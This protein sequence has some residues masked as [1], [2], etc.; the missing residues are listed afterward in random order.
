VDRALRNLKELQRENE[1][2]RQ[3]MQRIKANPKA[4]IKPIRDE[5]STKINQLREEND[6]LRRMV[7]KTKIPAYCE[8][9]KKKIIQPDYDDQT[10]NHES[11]RGSYRNRNPLDEI[12]SNFDKNDARSTCLNYNQTE[13]QGQRT[14]VVGQ[15]DQ[16]QR[17]MLMS[18]I[19]LMLEKAEAFED[20]L[21]KIT[22]KEKE[23]LR[24]SSR[25]DQATERE[26]A[27]IYEYKKKLIKLLS[28]LKNREIA[29]KDVPPSYSARPDL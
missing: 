11:M 7:E 3:E 19:R 18:E 5:F 20:E 16:E 22:R 6:S 10:S 29:M 17:D 15:N 25:R 23:E 4:F 24:G 12:E 21:E 8:M 26:L 28:K 9:T 13:I 1:S 27:R 2:L 14:Y